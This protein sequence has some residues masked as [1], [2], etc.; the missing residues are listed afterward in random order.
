MGEAV[1]KAAESRMLA[2]LAFVGQVSTWLTSRLADPRPF[3]AADYAHL[4]T[5]LCASLAGSIA[6]RRAAGGAES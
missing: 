1:R 4:V 5:M 6:A 2:V 3:G